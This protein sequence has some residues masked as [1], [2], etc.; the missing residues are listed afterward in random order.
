MECFALY[1][2]TW[3]ELSLTFNR[4]ENVA[5]RVSTKQYTNFRSL[6]RAIILTETSLLVD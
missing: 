6:T 5:N 3:A 4:I 1:L 2:S